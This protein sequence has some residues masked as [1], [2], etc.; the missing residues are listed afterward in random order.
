MTVEGRL[1]SC[2]HAYNVS[3]EEQFNL[4]WRDPTSNEPTSAPAL[5]NYAIIHTPTP[6]NC[7]ECPILTTG[8]TYLIAGQY[9]IRE[10]GNGVMWELPNKRTLSLASKWVDDYSDKVRKWIDAANDAKEQ[11]PAA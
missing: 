11:E 9:H 7:T 1:H 4:L 2:K 8:T 3:V 5:Q 10:D 6:A